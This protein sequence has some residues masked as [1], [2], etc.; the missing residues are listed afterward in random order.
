[1]SDAPEEPSDGGATVSGESVPTTLPDGQPF[2]ADLVFHRTMAQTHM[3]VCLTDPHREDNPIVFVNDAFEALTGYPPAEALGRNCRFLQGPETD[4]AAIETIRDGLRGEDVV[5]LEI[6]NYRRDGERF[7]NAL[8]LGPVY[9]D[10]GRLIYFFATQWD[11]SGVDKLRAERDREREHAEALSRRLRDLFTVVN[12]IVGLSTNTTN[13]RLG[14][15]LVQRILAVS[16]A[17]E[18]A[19]ETDEHGT[20]DL[21]RVLG[22]VLEPYAAGTG[23]R[24]SITGRPLRIERNLVAMLAVAFHELATAATRHGALGRD[25]GLVDVSWRSVRPSGAQQVEILWSEETVADGEA[26]V[27]TPD[28]QLAHELVDELA[29]SIDGDF[30]VTLSERML[31]ARL[32]LPLSLEQFPGPSEA[33]RSSA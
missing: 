11:V 5:V 13:R 29:E 24:I 28:E 18:A 30:A 17:Y 27:V 2:P 32:L 8:H 10:A 7:V 6:V 14:H 15:V 4:P 33:D 19:F 22:T 9:D 16:R 12:A 21:A 3:S 1:M 25:G 31:E 26:R 20:V 23:E